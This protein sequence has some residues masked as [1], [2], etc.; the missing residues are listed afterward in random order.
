M[1]VVAVILV[2]WQTVATAWPARYLPPFT[3]VLSAYVELLTGD[4]L[5]GDIVPSLVRTLAGF[6]VA[7]VVGVAL[8]INIG[9]F[10]RLDAWIRPVLEFL[11]AL[12]APAVVPAALI[13]LGVGAQMRI[14]VIAFGSVFPVLLNTIDGTRRVDDLMLDTARAYGLAPLAIMWRVVVPAASPQIMAGIRTA[15]AVALIM[16]VISE[17][18]AATSGIGALVLQSQR[19]FQVPQT[20]AGVL[21]IGTIGW[22]LTNA[23]LAIERRSMGWHRAWRTGAS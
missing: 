3:D 23:L 15:S 8:G 11:R 6:A 14:A 13:L 9:Y 20:Y 17:L 16:M 7:V 18:I 1:V 19:L 10:R 12:P 21:V 22:L 5:L 4:A 2:A